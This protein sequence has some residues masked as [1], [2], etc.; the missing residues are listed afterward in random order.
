MPFSLLLVALMAFEPAPQGPSTPVPTF[1]EAVQAATAGND[2]QALV[3][4]QRLAS[5]NPNDHQ[6]RLWI[7]RLHE[8]MGHWDQAEPVYRSVLLEDPENVDAMLGVA[9]SLLARDEPAEALK[10]LTIAEERAPENDAVLAAIGRAHRQ[11]GR[12]ARALPYFERAFAIAPTE[13]HR[14]W[15][16][17][18]R[19]SYLHRVET[20]GFSEQFNGST[21]NSHSGDVALNLRVKETLRVSGRGQVQRKFGISEQR[22]GG[23]LEWQW[24]PALTLRGQALFGP[25][26]Q[27]IPEGDIL[28]E[29][30][31][32]RGPAT[33]TASVRYFD[34]TG[35]RTSVASPAVTWEASDR[36]SLGLLYAVSWT[37]T[38]I[39]PSR[40][41][42]VSGHVHGAYRLYPR[43]WVQAGY[44]AG[45]EDFD[46]FTIDRIGDFRAN[47]VSAGVRVHLPTLTHVIGTYEYQ[48]Q[49]SSVHM[50]RVTLSLAQRF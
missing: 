27:V 41:A 35:A 3:A 20:R 22:A 1:D 12:T 31:Y 44:A 19:L 47:T 13:Q 42:G 16:E 9:T 26:N 10:L 49:Q 46:T 48:A 7:A 24:K 18:A 21:P 15:L 8:R 38:N 50:S 14:G 11:S 25:D 32:R 36:L 30:E 34:F 17:G 2:E 29:L 45:V 39:V 6:A 43:V 28:G 40:V 4:F 33:W 23:G 5:I 37:E